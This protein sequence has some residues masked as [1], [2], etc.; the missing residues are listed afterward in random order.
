MVLDGIGR[1]LGLGVGSVAKVMARELARG[2]GA[3]GIVVV[4]GDPLARA[5][6]AAGFRVVSVSE[7]PRRRRSGPPQIAASSIALPFRDGVAPRRPERRHDEA[8]QINI[9]LHDGEAAGEEEAGRHREAKSIDALCAAGVPLDPGGAL[10]EWAR[11]V[12]PG[13]LVAVATAASTLVRKVEPPEA[14]AAHIL[15]ALLVD[16]EQSEVG[17]MLITTARIPRF[18]A[19]IA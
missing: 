12:R 3:S 13:G 16:I 19:A 6:A 1:T 17:S 7:R 8:R 15:H 10:R 11:V 18:R 9:T 5:L 14:L 4:L 2:G